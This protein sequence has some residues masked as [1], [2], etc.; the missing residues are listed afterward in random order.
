M[1]LDPGKVLVVM[2]GTC[3]VWA[4]MQVSTP[5]N[6]V[7]VD[8]ELYREVMR[9]LRSR[10]VWAMQLR[11]GVGIRDGTVEVLPQ[12]CSLDVF[13]RW[14]RAAIVVVV[15]CSVAILQIDGIWL[16]VALPVPTR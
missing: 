9:E 6:L 2:L 14:T 15:R 4:K 3:E 10:G 16:Q 8:M 13:F 12:S 5:Q 7:N 11:E 1:E